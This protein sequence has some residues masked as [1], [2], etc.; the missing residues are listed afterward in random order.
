MD[1]INNI[2]NT[3]NISGIKKEESKYL[4]INPEQL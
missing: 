1:N 2:D 3:E 4:E